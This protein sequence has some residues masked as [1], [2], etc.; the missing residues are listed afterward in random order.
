M[1]IRFLRCLINK[2]VV[3]GFLVINRFVRVIEK[4]IYFV[5]FGVDIFVDFI[6]FSDKSYIS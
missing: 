5:E 1:D 4:E 3:Y 2:L 6:Y